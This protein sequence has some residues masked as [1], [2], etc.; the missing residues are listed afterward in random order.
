MDKYYTQ[1]AD[2]H[3]WLVVKY[4]DDTLYPP[5][6]QYTLIEKTDFKDERLYFKIKE[7]RSK[8]KVASISYENATK[9]L[10]DAKGPH[11]DAGKLYYNRK[12]GQLWYGTMSRREEGLSCKL[13]PEN[14]PP[15]GLYDLEIP[16]EIHPIGTR[17]YEYSKYATTWFR[18][19]HQGDRYLHPGNV[20]LGCVTLTALGEWTSIY[21]YLIARRKG[22]GKSVGTIEIADR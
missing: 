1:D 7:G 8:G 5:L 20:S 21:N 2:G 10:A 15:N 6:P 16:D 14:P 19:G 18:I 22:D 13:Y 3:G 9:Y 11:A 4:S 17:Y 12:K